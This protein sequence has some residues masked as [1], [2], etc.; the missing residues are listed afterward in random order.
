M[1]IRRLYRGLRA[2]VL[3]RMIPRSRAPI[4]AGQKQAIEI[5]GFFHTASGLGESARQCALQLHQQG[6]KIRCI[7]VE[8]FFLKPVELE[9]HLGDTAQEHEVGCRILHLN[10]P[11]LPPVIFRLGLSRYRRVFNVGVW[12][13]E[14][15]QIPQEWR[16]ALGYINAIICPSEFTSTA[17]R[18]YT[19]KPVL[20]VAH[21]V[22]AG[23]AQ[24]GVRQALGLDEGA[25]VVTSVFSFGSAL[26]RKNPQAMVS[27]F[28]QAFADT[29][30]AHMVLKTN[31]A[32]DS[33]ATKAFMAMIA[34]HANI[35][36]IGEIWDKEKIV[37]LLKESDVCLSLHRSEGFGLTMAEAMLVGTPVVATDWSGN[38]DFCNDENSYP[39][40]FTPIAVDSAH[41]EFAGMG[42]MTWADADVSHAAEQLRSILDDPQRA[43]RKIAKAF[44]LQSFFARP[45]YTN[46][47]NSLRQQEKKPVA[48]PAQ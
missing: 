14:L 36:Q 1:F 9:W 27:A 29:P 22:T 25:F 12:A 34:Q 37:G 18:Q 11:M 16:N 43:A 45:A 38:T 47:L 5:V 3:Q 28:L 26:E 21:P 10:P 33:D 39:V 32:D 20:T 42:A 23:I 24:E 2:T 13:W 31:R 17:I 40:R 41:P 46:A 19:D 8:R 7:S 35:T 15:E 6:H 44:E 48:S 30:N 4:F